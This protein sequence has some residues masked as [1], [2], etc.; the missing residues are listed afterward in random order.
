MLIVLSK[1]FAVVTNAVFEAAKLRNPKKYLIFKHGPCLFQILSNK[2]IGAILLIY[3]SQKDCVSEPKRGNGGLQVN[4][5]VVGKY[6]AFKL[7]YCL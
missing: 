3:L 6:C 1:L 5:R 4:K 2:H 7:L